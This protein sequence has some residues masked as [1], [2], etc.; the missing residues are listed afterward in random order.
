V[1]VEGPTGVGKTT[2][3]TRLAAALDAVAVLDPYE[4]NQLLPQFAAGGPNLAL[5]LQVELTFVALRVAQLRQIAVLLDA[6]RAVVADW[7]LL[8]L[9]IFAAT[10]LDPSDTVRV[11]ATVDVWASSVPTP[12]LLIG[13]SAPTG[14]LQ[15][16]IRARGRVFEAG[17]TDGYLADL[18]AAFDAAFAAWPGRQLPIAADRFNTFDDRTVNDLAHEIRDALTLVETR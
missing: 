18:S 14:T 13:I 16:R 12:D 9:A 6:G 7:A 8:K 4:S 10:V 2:L 11:A 1:A 3:A 17:L 15:T 5:A